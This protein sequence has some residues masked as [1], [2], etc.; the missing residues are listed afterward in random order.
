MEGRGTVTGAL[1]RQGRWAGRGDGLA[2][3]L[4]SSPLQGRNRKGRGEKRAG[5]PRLS[6][7]GKEGLQVT[8]E[9][10]VTMRTEKTLP[11]QG[12]RCHL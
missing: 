11:I 8:L 5:P 1:G 9:R 10:P 3:M 6:C 12:H 2:V 4:S 7:V